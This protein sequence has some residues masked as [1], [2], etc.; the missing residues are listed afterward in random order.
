MEGRIAMKFK[1]DHLIGGIIKKFRDE[2]NLTQENLGI[3]YRP[4]RIPH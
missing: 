3:I 4:N 1:I 2:E